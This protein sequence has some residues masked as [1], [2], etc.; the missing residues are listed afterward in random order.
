MPRRERFPTVDEKS[1]RASN[2]S[3]SYTH[4]VQ[5]EG[6]FPHHRDQGPLAAFGTLAFLDSVP[7][8]DAGFLDQSHGRKV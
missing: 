7:L 6:Q 2:G 3:S 4:G 5:A 8:H 1:R